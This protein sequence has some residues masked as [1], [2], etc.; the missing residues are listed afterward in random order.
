MMMNYI[1]FHGWR[2]QI[3]YRLGLPN[4]R[5][6]IRGGDMGRGDMET[7]ELVV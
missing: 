3:R 2:Q 7:D 1:G 4:F 6:D 5:P